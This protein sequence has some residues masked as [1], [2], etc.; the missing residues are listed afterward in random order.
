MSNNPNFCV[1]SDLD[2]SVVPYGARKDKW[3]E[4]DEFNPYAGVY[5]KHHSCMQCGKPSSTFRHYTCLKLDCYRNWVR[6]QLKLQ[7]D[8]TQMSSEVK[9]QIL[10]DEWD[11]IPGSRKFL[12]S[13]I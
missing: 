5:Y 9:N 4:I 1:Q 11:R 10:K 3:S 7:D 12:L 13:S 6:N 8:W 2:V